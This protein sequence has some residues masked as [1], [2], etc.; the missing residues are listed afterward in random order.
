[1]LSGSD[2]DNSSSELDPVRPKK[3]WVEKFYLT[4]SNWWI[5]LHITYNVENDLYMYIELRDKTETEIVQLNMKHLRWLMVKN[6][7]LI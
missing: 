6:P 3:E 2:P 7:L 1:M 5:L 4:F